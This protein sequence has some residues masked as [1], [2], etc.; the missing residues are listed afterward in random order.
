M[1]Y[2]RIINRREGKRAQ[3]A[4]ERWFVWPSGDVIP[5]YYRSELSYPAIMASNLRPCFVSGAPRRTGALAAVEEASLCSLLYIWRF[6]THTGAVHLEISLFFPNNNPSLNS[7]YTT[8]LV[9]Y[10][11]FN[12]CTFGDIVIGKTTNP[13]RSYSFLTAPHCT[14]WGLSF[15]H[16]YLT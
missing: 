16:K 10:I 11:N 13:S 7:F 12:C 5:R 1:L 3:R 4:S 6:R 15:P 9:R 8:H 2:G 14:I